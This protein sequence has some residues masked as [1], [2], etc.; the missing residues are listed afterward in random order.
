MRIIAGL[1]KRKKLFSPKTA[2]IRPTSDRLRE[3]VFNIL[4]RELFSANVLDLFAGT[5]ALGLEALSRG[6]SFCV[7]VDNSLEAISLI[8]R[9]ITLCEMDSQTVVYSK[10]AFS[11]LSFLTEYAPF[12]IVFIDPPYDKTD[13]SFLFGQL[14]DQQVLQKNAMLVVETSLKEAISFPG[15][16]FS[17]IKYRT[18]GKSRVSFFEYMV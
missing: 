6:S 10:D 14:H 12:S 13:F 9:N 11:D 1:Q 17:L 4:E 7:F 5:G 15:A 2:N 16:L 8:Q 3:T 18:C